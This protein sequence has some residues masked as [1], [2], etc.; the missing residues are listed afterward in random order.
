M[1]WPKALPDAEYNAR[2]LERVFARCDKQPNGCWLWSG[3]IGKNGYGQTNYRNK[4]KRV[5][6]QVHLLVN[7]DLLP[8]QDV[9]HSC[10][11]RSCGNPLHL[12]AGTRK[13]NMRDC[14]EKGRAD[15]QW[16]TSCASGH[17]FTE[18]NT[19]RTSEGWR[20]C[21]ACHRI[22]QRVRSGWT[23]EEAE[24]MAMTPIPQGEKTARRQ[25]KFNKRKAA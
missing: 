19:R 3:T 25:F 24:V 18:E 22:R 17:P 15:R 14:S 20:Q 23:R 7:G 9:C 13:Q 10:D 1:A 16:M 21:K 6:R 8:G 5:H 11:N 4:T 2:W 12:W